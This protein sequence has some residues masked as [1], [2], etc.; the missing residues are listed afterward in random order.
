[1]SVPSL[2]GL[3]TSW[4]ED[5][6]P[7]RPG[8]LAALLRSRPDLCVPPPSDLGSLAARALARTSLVRALDSVDLPHL[9]VLECLATVGPATTQ[10]IAAF[11]GVP[12][13]PEIP[14]D[15]LQHLQD[16]ALVVPS[17][18]QGAW[19]APVQVTA[20]VGNLGLCLGRPAAG[21]G[22]DPA[23]LPTA[24]DELIQRIQ[25]HELVQRDPGLLAAVLDAVQTLQTQP[26]AR[27]SDPPGPV[28]QVL[29]DTG[30]VVR[31][32]AAPD[33]TELAEH[34]LEAALAWRRGTAGVTLSLSAPDAPGQTVLGPIARNAAL[35]AVTDLLRECL[36]VLAALEDGLPTLRSGGV[37]VRE[38]RRLAVR[39]GTEA[40]HA[41]W[42][43]E[44]LVAAGLV[45]LDPDTSE[46]QHSSAVPHWRRASRARQWEVLVSGWLS[47]ARAPLWGPPVSTA[48]STAAETG[49]LLAP[50]RTR[51]DAPQLRA[52]VLGTATLASEQQPGIGLDA[53]VPHRLRWQHPRQHHRT[54]AFVPALLRETGLL[55]LTGAGA[56][57]ELGA[58]VAQG[59]L[60][61]AR[62]RVEELLPAPVTRF[63]LQGDLT[64]VA[65][66][67]LDPRLAEPLKL[68]A[69]PEGDG[70]A[71]QFRFS[72]E[73]LHR[74]LDAGWTAEQILQFLT[75]HSED[76]VPQSVEYLV[77]DVA[78]RHGA[79]VTGA[80]AAWLRAEDPDLLDA[81][82]ADPSLVQA[83]LERLA[84]TVLVAGVGPRE[85]QRLLATAGHRAAL[86]AV[87]PA[88]PAA[89]A[90]SRP[91][92]GQEPSADRSPERE[93]LA[94]TMAHSP[95]PAPLASP[96]RVPS[97]QEIDEVLERLRRAPVPMDAGTGP[98]QA[99]AVLRQAARTRQP[100]RLHLVTAQ[101][102]RRER[103]VVPLAV[104]GGR[105]R[106]QDLPGPDG[107]SA[108][109]GRES[110]L[111]LH[112]V[113]GAEPVTSTI[114]T[115]LAD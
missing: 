23:A 48:P 93:S 88:V 47:C 92:D 51:P 11:L 27:V 25:D 40:V 21:L 112:R 109:V 54:A 100:V 79:L 94:S 65:P 6:R 83:R 15:V 87:R 13:H 9:Q 42:L 60:P 115:G 45:E 32:G 29:L 1:M 97:D 96:R 61:A 36:A 90:A 75:E 18:P 3:F 30:L 107:S 76:R 82:L 35:A 14:D 81:V 70:P 44:L 66:G 57:T 91:D 104:A 72:D 69:A 71:Q 5:A 67:Y 55:G 46:W 4:L 19:S 62:E 34:P 41:A 7:G 108:P 37:G 78:R 102:E 39:T 58:L 20:A 38:V 111:P 105:L 22:T 114:P 85:L 26:V 50:D 68:M 33:G 24:R 28:L 98:E 12:D 89:S 77:R 43:V 101:G 10:E 103:L 8:R 74:A 31:A 56:L 73:S 110:V 113:V 52:T 53:A 49:R 2:T 106:C 99:V 16:L 64:A 80:A 86:A 17:G 84:P 59:D 63:R 95:F